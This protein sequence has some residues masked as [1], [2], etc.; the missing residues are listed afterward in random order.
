MTMLPAPVVATWRRNARHDRKT[1]V[2]VR[3]DRGAPPLVRHLP[4]GDLLG[5]PHAGVRDEHIEAAECLD[6]G[7]DEG[8]GLALDR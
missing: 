1:R 5:W 8:V 7:G 2:E 3:G 4:D 6:R